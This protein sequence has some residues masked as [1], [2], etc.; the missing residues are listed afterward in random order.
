MHQ[1]IH[2]CECSRALALGAPKGERLWPISEVLAKLR[3]AL[4]SVVR[5]RRLS[6]GPGRLE[7]HA[8][9]LASPRPSPDRAAR[10]TGRAPPDG[11]ALG[12]PGANAPRGPRGVDEVRG[13][14]AAHGP[15]RGV[16]HPTPRPGARAAHDEGREDRGRLLVDGLQSPQAEVGIATLRGVLRRPMPRPPLARP[17]AYIPH[18]AAGL[19]ARACHRTS[20]GHTA[21]TVVSEFLAA[22]G[23]AGGQD[24]RGRERG[25]QC[26]FV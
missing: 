14:D 1:S 6:A 12:A 10:V 9:A 23:G 17:K 5:R 16:G 24:G 7:A 4:L 20:T 15:G 22:M 19:S 26:G 18:H 3:I 25:R 21:A 8:Q 2:P 13:G 11:R